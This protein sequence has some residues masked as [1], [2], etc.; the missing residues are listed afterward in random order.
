M[1]ATAWAA[2]SP[3]AEGWMD[4]YSLVCVEGYSVPDA[5]AMLNLPPA[6]VR[7]ARNQVLTWLATNKP[8]HAEKSKD[9]ALRLSEA[10]A[11]ERLEHLYC[12]AMEAWKNS[13]QEEVQTRQEGVLARTTRTIKTSH[14]KVCYLSMAAK[15]A[16]MLMKIPYRFVPSWME[17]GA[18]ANAPIRFQL[19]AGERAARQK[20]AAREAATGGAEERDLR[21]TH[22][23][24][25]PPVGDCSDFVRATYEGHGPL[26]DAFD[27]MLGEAERN[28]D[29]LRRF[30]HAMDAGARLFNPVQPPLSDL[31]DDDEAD[32]EE[33]DDTV[34]SAAAEP[35]GFSAKP[36]AVQRPSLLPKETRRPLSRKERRARQKLLAKAK[37]RTG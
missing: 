14:G 19:D 22:A 7:Q 17:E 23:A 25:T 12:E 24:A 1:V 9:E 20:Q 36:Q 3:P 37:K 11:R 34:D 15:I 31:L 32:E 5:A 2:G 28:G 8:L 35:S 33:L 4:V 21:S 18:A 16:E 13:Q 6:K 10:M 29:S 27:A 26:E 30:Q